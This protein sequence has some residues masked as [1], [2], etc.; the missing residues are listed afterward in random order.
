MSLEAFMLLRASILTTRKTTNLQA[1]RST[2]SVPRSTLL[3]SRRPTSSSLGSRRVSSRAISP[4]AWRAETKT[5]RRTPPSPRSSRVRVQRVA[6]ARALY[7]NPVMVVLDEPNA[8]LDESGSQALNA[9]IRTLKARGVMTVVI[10]HRPSVLA[11]CDLI[12]SLKGGRV[13]VLE[14]NAKLLRTAAPRVVWATRRTEG[15]VA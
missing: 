15:T 9:A 2:S 8:S 1:E 13:D 5:S 6:L 11:D 7:G 12:L 3:S 4:R 14:P 10:A